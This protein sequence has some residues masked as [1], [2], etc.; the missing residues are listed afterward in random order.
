MAQAKK[1][2]AASSKAKA[3]APDVSSGW[4]AAYPALKQKLA[5]LGIFRPADLVTH[6]PLRYEDHTRLTPLADVMPGIACQIEGTVIAT[7]IHYRPWR[8]LVTTLAQGDGQVVLR[9]LHFYPSQQKTLAA[10]DRKSVV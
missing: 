2:K 6:L 4:L 7:Q 5:K 1:R 10:G 9:F 3:R 8:Q